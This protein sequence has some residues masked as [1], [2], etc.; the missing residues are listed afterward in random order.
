MFTTA[1]KDAA[2]ET[3]NDAKTTAYRAKRD[4]ENSMDDATST[5]GNRLDRA[6]NDVERVAVSAGRKVRGLMDSAN[7]QISDASDAVTGEIRSNPLRSSAIAL[8]VGFVIGALF[9]R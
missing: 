8:G 4:I 6:A 3:L 7:N 1:T 2:N 5:S 9:R